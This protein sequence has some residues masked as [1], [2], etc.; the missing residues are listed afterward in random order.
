MGYHHI[1]MVNDDILVGGPGT[2][3]DCEREFAQLK[4]TSLT[5][6]GDNLVVYK[7]VPVRAATA[8]LLIT[9]EEV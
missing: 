9:D 8:T 6:H 5:E 2:R 7:L 1:V 4:A 3:A